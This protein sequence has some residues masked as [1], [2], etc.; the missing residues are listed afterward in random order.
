MIARVWSGTTT[1]GNAAGYLAHLRD[2]TFPRLSSIAGFRGGHVLSRAR[3]DRVEFTVMTLWDSL[4][5]IR[6]FAGDDT[7]AAVV[8][9]EA[10]ALLVSFETR[11]SHWDALNA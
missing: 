3:G 11:A 10:Q 5:A 1:S 4:D 6:Q 7:E 8:P 2:H 9:P